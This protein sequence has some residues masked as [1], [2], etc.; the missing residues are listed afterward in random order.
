LAEVRVLGSGGCAVSS[1]QAG[2]GKEE[3]EGGDDTEYK[4]HPEADIACKSEG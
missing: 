3:N 1:N 2:T 4:L